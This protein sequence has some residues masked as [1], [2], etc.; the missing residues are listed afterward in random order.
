MAEDKII[1]VKGLKRFKEKQDL[2]NAKIYATRITGAGLPTE[3]LYVGKY[4][5]NTIDERMYIYTSSGWRALPFA[6]EIPVKYNSNGSISP[7]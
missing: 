2:E 3:M 5:F 6:D 4:F 7:K 1:T